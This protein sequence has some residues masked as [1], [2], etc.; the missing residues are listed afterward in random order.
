MSKTEDLLEELDALWRVRY[1]QPLPIVA[2]PEL[3]VRV[4]RRV[5]EKRQAEAAAPPA[6][7]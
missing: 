6:P 7:G 2:E 1:G 3:I 5:E 4:M